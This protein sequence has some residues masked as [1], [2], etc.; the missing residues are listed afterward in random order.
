MQKKC[1]TN[2]IIKYIRV[3]LS[4]VVIGL[5]IYFKSWL[6][7]LGVLTLISAFTGNCALS[8]N[9]KRDFDFELDKSKPEKKQEDQKR[10]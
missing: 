7:A 5:G 8:P 10:V 3:A 9:F 6:G 2:P 1:N 4:L